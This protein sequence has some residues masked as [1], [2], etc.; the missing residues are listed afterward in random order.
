MRR[1]DTYTPIKTRDIQS[2]MQAIREQGILSHTAYCRLHNYIVTMER[3]MTT[4]LG[5]GRE[6]SLDDFKKIEPV[7]KN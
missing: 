2:I 4:H 7:R 5:T 1:R 6:L 3:L